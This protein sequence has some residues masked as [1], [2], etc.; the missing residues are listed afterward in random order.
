MLMVKVDLSNYNRVF[1]ESE[2][3]ELK[4]KNF[5]YGKNGTG[6]S[7]LCDSIIEQFNKDFDI[8]IFQ[9]FES[10][11]SEDE[12]LNSIVLGE[13]NKKVQSQINQKLK[14]IEQKTIIL[15]DAV[16]C[17]QSLNGEEGVDESPF[18]IQY[19]KSKEDIRLKETK[20]GS[21]YQ[22]GASDLTIKFN[23]GRTYNRNNFKNDIQNSE[24]LTQDEYQKLLTIS[25]AVKKNE[26]IEK[27]Y[28]EINLTRY[29]KSLNEISQ[30][31][32]EAVV[33]SKELK[34]D[35][36]KRKFA[37][38]GL[39]IHREGDKCVF[40][41]G[42]VTGNRIRELKSFFN[43][44]EIFMLQEKVKNGISTIDESLEYLDKI[45]PLLQSSFYNHFEI[46]NLNTQ[47]LIVKNEQMQFLK[48]CK[49]QLIKKE[50]ELFNE[51]ESF[52]IK[53]P[54]D[55]S[56]IQEDINALIR[57]NN[58]FS[59]RIE[60]NIKDAESKMKL[61]FIASK[62]EEIGYEKLQGE[63]SALTKIKIEM[64]MLLDSEIEKNTSKKEKVE[65]DINDTNQE[66]KKLQMKIKNPEIIIEKI[67]EKILK[68]GKQ[69]LKLK[70]IKSGKH[71]EILNK[72]G[73]TRNIKEISTGEK[74]I[75]AFLYFIGSLE[76]PDLDSG[77]PKIIILDDPMNSNDDT[78]QYLIIS[79]IEKLYN[80]KKLYSYFILL[81]HNSHFYLKVTYSRRSRRDNKN[82]YEID[83]FVRMVSDGNLTSFK[84][85][86]DKKE[87]FSTQ[88][89]SLWKELEFLFEKDKKD[90]MCNT[91][92]RI[93]ETYIIFNGVPGNKDAESKMLFNTNSHYAEVGDL[94]TDTNGYTREQ[95]IELLK[96]FFRTNNAEKH[97]NTYWKL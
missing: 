71:Y 26:I 10:V 92:R 38:V 59:N 39:E 78:M 34:S 43:S 47:L 62:C 31:R 40:C 66:I 93:I 95:I 6:K 72:D 85:L 97:F 33:I 41:E 18:L 65:A 79:E 83:N 67:N 54:S 74:N 30:S 2:L 91:I 48:D 53:I 51:V 36:E 7:T 63:L 35:P 60:E 3:I 12:K 96:Q 77:K 9:G 81:T 21:F 46:K 64:K 28:P 69:N 88:Y 82:A 8:R 73:S 68:S 22:K 94:E 24:K 45:E 61:H 55:F 25:K 20:I 16:C 1:V 5:F 87:D 86:G 75:I 89:G 15:D 84:R 13:E 29:L 19:K 11:I 80:R 52:T 70:Y 4:D 50:K 58:E 37:E 23:F 49:E 32:V 17:I 27:K 57:Q 90:F 14:S 76:S 56:S 44:E 42:E